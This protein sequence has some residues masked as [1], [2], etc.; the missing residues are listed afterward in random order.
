MKYLVIFSL[1]ILFSSGVVAKDFHFKDVPEGFWATDAVYDL[2]KMGVTKGYPDGT[3]RGKKN[4]TRYEVAALL[5]KFA[6]SLNLDRG[7]KE[8]I[9]EELKTEVALIKYKNEKAAKISGYAESRARATSIAPRGGKIDYRLKVNWFRKFNA[10]SSLKIGLDTVDAGFNSA[11]TREIATRLID[12][13]SRFKIGGLNYKVNL[14]P[15]VVVHTE[16]DGFFPSENYTIYIRPKSAIKV[17]GQKGKL[18]YSAS[19]VTRQMQTSG[20]IGVHEVTGK[21]KYKFGQLAVSLQPRYMFVLDGGRDVLADVGINYAWDKNWITYVLICAGDFQAGNSGLYA[22][23]IQKILDPAKTG[24]NIV[25][26]FDKVGSKYRHDIINEYE[27][28]YLNNFNRLILDGTVDIGLKINQKLSKQLAV[29]WKGDYVARGD[30][31]YGAAYPGTYSLW[32][33]SLLYNVA[34]NIGFDAFYRSYN[35]PSGIAQFSQAV[36]TVSDMFGLGVKCAF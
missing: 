27:F 14:G 16:S 33:L 9:I 31:Q 10:N 18:S 23:F 4:I 32:Q 1:I 13:E 19:Y 21:L 12:V 25:F 26:R 17:Y 2:V 8:K 15:G 11:T 24:T 20:L 28:I 7:K 6:Q 35:V 5:T 29:E 36:P 30:Y 3:F 22:K 34:S